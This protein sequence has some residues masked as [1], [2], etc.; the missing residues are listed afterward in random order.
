MLILRTCSHNLTSY[1]GF[2]W[3]ESGIAEAPDFS[4]R[5]C[6]GHGLHGLAWGEGNGDLSDPPYDLWWPLVG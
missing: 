4:P 1:N 3:P 5:D 2:R 6:C